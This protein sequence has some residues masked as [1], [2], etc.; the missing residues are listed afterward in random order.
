MRIFQ[1]NGWYHVGISR[2]KEISLHTKNRN[3]ALKNLKKLGIKKDPCPYCGGEVPWH[4]KYCSDSCRERLGNEKIRYG[5][6]RKFILDAF[7]N[8][9]GVCGYNDHLIIHHIDGFGSAVKRKDRNNKAENLIVLCSSCHLKIHL[10]DNQVMPGPD[11][12]FIGNIYPNIR[13]RI[14]AEMK[15]IQELK[16]ACK[17]PLRLPAICMR[18]VTINDEI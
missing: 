12:F 8:K 17:L 14:A 10:A 6:P 13:A 11:T 4:R 1:R 15:S 5:F 16:N 9:C 3:V 7:E 18:R 2:G